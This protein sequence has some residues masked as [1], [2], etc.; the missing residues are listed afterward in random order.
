MDLLDDDDLL[1]LR[2]RARSTDP[3]AV[4]AEER[5]GRLVL[6]SQ[7][8]DL[9]E[10]ASTPAGSQSEAPARG[11]GTAGACHVC[12]TRPGRSTC[13]NCGRKACHADMW[14]MLRLCR[15][16]AKDERYRADGAPEEP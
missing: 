15:A 5:S 2:R 9:D 7:N 13:A 12:G 1:N 8:R 14:V 11:P 10:W 4:V 6:P 16:C 3:E